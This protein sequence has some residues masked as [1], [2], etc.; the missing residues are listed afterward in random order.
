MSKLRTFAVPV[1]VLKHLF[2]GMFSPEAVGNRDVA[3]VNAANHGVASSELGL[4][5]GNALKEPAIANGGVER[6]PLGHA[7]D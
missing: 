4:P 2:N 5:S 1:D 7:L 3:G 6:P